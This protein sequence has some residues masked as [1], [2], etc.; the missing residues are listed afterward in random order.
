[1]YIK[2][3]LVVVL[4]HHNGLVVHGPIL[5]QNSLKIFNKSVFFFFFES[6]SI[7]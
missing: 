6:I 4:V 3:V 2:L 5:N 1:M 7:G